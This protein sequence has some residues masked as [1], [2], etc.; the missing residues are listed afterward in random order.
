MLFAVL[1]LEMLGLS[2][3]PTGAEERLTPDHLTTIFDPPVKPG[4]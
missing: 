3:V 1:M 2:A 4:H